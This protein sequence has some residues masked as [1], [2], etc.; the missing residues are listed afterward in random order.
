M[1]TSGASS[2]ALAFAESLQVLA[3]VI[4]PFSVLPT[5]TSSLLVNPLGGIQSVE[6][7]VLYLSLIFFFICIEETVFPC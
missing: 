5:S 7:F 4:V 1:L 2:G 3:S 6:T